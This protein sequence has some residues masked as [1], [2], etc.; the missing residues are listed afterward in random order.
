MKF[1]TFL[2]ASLILLFWAPSAQCQT[3]D[4]SEA[5]EALRIT[6]NKVLPGNLNIDAFDS[7][8]TGANCEVSAYVNLSGGARMNLNATFN[9]SEDNKNVEVTGSLEDVGIGQLL[10][11]FGVSNP[12]LPGDFLDSEINALSVTINPVEK[13]LTAT[14]EINLGQLEISGNKG[15]GFMMGIR[16]KNLG[17]MIGLNAIN[18]ALNGFTL[19]YSSKSAEEDSALDLLSDVNVKSGLNLYWTG[20]L[21][22]PLRTFLSPAGI[23]GINNSKTF[24][25]A[26]S[27]TSQVSM[28]TL[29]LSYDLGGF[30]LSILKFENIGLNLNLSDASIGLSGEIS[31][32]ELGNNFVLNGSST[33]KFNPLQFEYALSV[34]DR[35]N[36]LMDYIPGVKVNSLHTGGLVTSGG[37]ATIVVGGEAA[38]GTNEP[39]TMGITIGPGTF[40]GTISEL[41]I[42]AIIKA[43]SDVNLGGLKSALDVGITNGTVS[44][45][46][47]TKE[48]LF[49]GNANLF[50]FGSYFEMTSKNSDFS[51]WADLDPIELKSGGTTLFRLTG[52]TDRGGAKFDLNSN[53]TGSF[54]G[55]VELLGGD[56]IKSNMSIT[57]SEIKFDVEQKLYGGGLSA[58]LVVTATNFTNFH[59]AGF[60][61]DATI[62]NKLRPKIVKLIEDELESVDPLNF[63][64]TVVDEALKTFEVRKMGFKTKLKGFNK[65]KVNVHVDSRLAGQKIPINVTVNLDAGSVDKIANAVAKEIA[66][67]LQKAGSILLK[68]LEDIGA[69][70]YLA[71][72]ETIQWTEGAANTTANWLSGAI[73]AAGEWIVGAGGKIISTFSS[74]RRY[75]CPNVPFTAPANGRIAGPLPPGINQYRIKLHHIKTVAKGHEDNNMLEIWGSITVKTNMA[76]QEDA[77]PWL[78]NNSCRST[79]KCIFNEANTEVSHFIDFFVA[80]DKRSTVTGEIE[81]ELYEGDPGVD[82]P[83]K[84]ETIDFVYEN[85]HGLPNFPGRVYEHIISLEEDHSNPQKI[86]VLISIERIYEPLHSPFVHIQKSGGVSADQYLSFNSSENVS[87]SALN[88]GN[89]LQ[90]WEVVNRYD[91]S[92]NIKINGGTNPDKTYLGSTTN[93]DLKFYDKDDGSSPQRWEF[94]KNSD[95]T[96]RIKI[97]GGTNTDKKYLSVTFDGKMALMK[98]PITDVDMVAA[99][100]RMLWELEST[101]GVTCED[102][103]RNQGETKTDC[104]G[105]NCDPCPSCDD[106]LLNNEE[107]GIDC[108]GPNCVVCPG[109]LGGTFEGGIIIDMDEYQNPSLLGQIGPYFKGNWQD[110][111]AY[112]ASYAGGGHTG[113]RLPYKSELDLIHANAYKKGK[114]PIPTDALYWGRHYS[115]DGAIRR[116]ITKG[117][118]YFNNNPN[119]NGDLY[120]FCVTNVSVSAQDQGG[121][122]LGSL[123]VAPNDLGVFNWE[124]AKTACG[125]YGGGGFTNWR[126]PTSDELSDI[127]NGLVNRGL[128]DFNT[129]DNTFYWAGNVEP[130]RKHL[131]KTYRG[132]GKIKNYDLIPPDPSLIVRPV[133]SFTTNPMC[134]DGIKNQGEEDVDCGGPCLPCPTCYDGIKNQGEMSTDK[135][136]PNCD[137]DGGSLVQIGDFHEEGFVFWIDE[138]GKRGKICAWDVLDYS[139]WSDAKLACEEHVEGGFSNWYLPS[140]EELLLIRSNI[141]S[142]SKIR[143]F[144][145]T[146]HRTGGTGDLKSFEK[147]WSSTTNGNKAATVKFNETKAGSWEKSRSARSLPIRSFAIP[148]KCGDGI[149]NQGE[150]EIDC[151]GP[152][153][154]CPTCYDGIQNQ[155]EADIDCGG[156]NCDPCLTCNDGIQNQGE[157]GIDC[158]GPN[159]DPCP[160]CDDGIRNQGE[161]RVDCGGPNCDPCPTCNDGVQN[162]DETGVDCGGPNCAPCTT[163]FGDADYK[164]VS[165]ATDKV[166]DLNRNTGGIAAYN[167]HGGDNQ[168]WNI[169]YVEG[170]EYV[171]I[172][173]KATGKVLDLNRYT[174][175]VAAYNFHG[176][177]NQLW[178]IE[179]IAGRDYAKIVSKATGK[180]LDLNRNTGGIAQWN[181][182]GGDN[183]LWKIESL[184][185]DP[186][187]SCD[188]GILNQGETGLDCGG[189]KCEPC[190]L[191]VTLENRH[192]KRLLF[193]TGDPA[194]GNEGGWTNSP[195]ILGT[196]L[197]YYNKGDWYLIKNADGTYYL[198]NSMNGRLLFS[199]GPPVVSNEGGGANSP[200]VVGADANY[201]NRARW[202]LEKQYNGY[203]TLKNKETNRFLFSP[204][205]AVEGNEGGWTNSPP[206][207]GTY[208]NDYNRANWKITGPGAAVLEK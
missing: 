168:R 171:K 103:I 131:V 4:A 29:S 54:T 28:P 15:D 53:L 202:I 155:G 59:N 83:F 199:T 45:D 154:A 186:C 1:K 62:N 44:V 97:K 52:N 40:E 135:G 114:Q 10:Q 88:Q 107:V 191:K 194:E 86:E 75:D 76:M 72:K 25:C 64:G 192:T 206:I 35:E 183:Q 98:E 46:R 37:G 27:L 3:I 31:T 143:D 179:T 184:D 71:G 26:E 94:H 41:S 188:D 49:K 23:P 124:D 157:T 165:K 12:D 61:I 166:F 140:K 205:K 100:E 125:E 152:C 21:P 121:I 190:P 146:L 127:E 22:G 170:T 39:I 104:G 145:P 133:R 207:L 144:Y 138:T 172:L 58:K 70:I 33:A 151:G 78:Y 195:A 161:Y 197:N 92:Y 189:P 187:P 148:S 2:I 56:K 73:G 117:A 110:A 176:G 50:G 48:T 129:Q 132:F 150:S 200:A 120:C 11:G 19:I 13:M 24:V 42:P 169:E 91:G 85:R 137:P 5:T 87:L 16:P 60:E 36:P 136:G 96:Y 47:T 175:G 181:F 173:S 185:C 105:P 113:W 74:S 55:D 51:M 67:E 134:N 93:G 180:V 109:E 115:G 43:F 99:K 68:G 6:V 108:G 196:D 90:T 142:N 20:K 153:L 174:G 116:D 147:L 167:Y 57:P 123:V 149:Q 159:C 193:S 203:Y 17:N 128:A 9:A 141:H 102:S 118:D 204:G 65:A 106:G 164:I 80:S 84:T 77:N 14:M 95:G 156:P 89:N 34:G 69:G 163:A 63:V 208:A 178:K 81:L 7:D 198:K 30:D 160:T 79:T 126:L 82:D 177:D 119:S 201:Y 112:C 66:K 139:N 32:S 38:I 130:G 162:Q 8:G 182:H 101:T 18:S 111:E 158:G 122:I